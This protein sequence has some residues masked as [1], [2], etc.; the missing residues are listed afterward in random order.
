MKKLI[1]LSVVL[2]SVVAIVYLY[3]KSSGAHPG[4][5]GAPGENSCADAATGCHEDAIVIKGDNVNE[6]LFNNLPTI[7]FT[8]NDFYTIT[9]KVKEP[10]GVR[11]GF[12]VVALD[13]NKKS[14]GKLLKPVIDNK[15]VQL[16]SN[17]GRSYV[18]HTSSSISPA[19]KGQNEWEF[20]WQAPLDYKGNVTFYYATNVSNG[21]QT[22]KGDKIYLSSK[23]I[24]NISSETSVKDIQQNL[25]LN[26]YPNPSSS[27]VTIGLPLE[28][29]EGTLM[30]T[31]TD[32]QGNNIKLTTTTLL[33]LGGVSTIMLPPQLTNGTFMLT[34]SNGKFTANQYIV[35]S[36]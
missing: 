1:T 2:F 16:L 33:T 34:V 26:V 31:L 32:L 36:K 7:K 24:S 10:T 19:T 18:T 15:R 14:I 13:D 29:L 27:L 6:I 9:V 25:S 30:Y 11:Y 23:T 4:S 20:G 22:F 17:A 28:L 8:N 35:I 21:D 5:T 3:A 12:E